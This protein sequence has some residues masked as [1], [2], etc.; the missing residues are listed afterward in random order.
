MTHPT[1]ARPLLRALTH[2]PLI[3]SFSASTRPRLSHWPRAITVTQKHNRSHPRS[4]FTT[5]TRTMASIHVDDKVKDL[6]IKSYPQAQDAGDDPHKLSIT[7]FPH[8]EVRTGLCRVF[9]PLKKPIL[10][11]SF[12]NSTPNPKRPRSSNGSSPP[13]TSPPQPKTQ[14][15]RPSASPP[16]T[17]TCRPAPPCSAASPPSPTWAC[18]R[19][20]RP[21]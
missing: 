12:I 3:R 21:S 16:S 18:T 11:D 14:P 1:L 7:A 4:P 17:P 15:R 9:S 13:P 2:T 8:V 10:T 20:W 6:I 5:P 19:A